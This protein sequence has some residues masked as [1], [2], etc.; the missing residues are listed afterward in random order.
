[1]PA[2]SV[3]G[4]R[5]GLKQEKPNPACGTKTANLWPSRAWLGILTNAR[6]R[7][8]MLIV[9]PTCRSQLRIGDD[10]LGR[11]IRCPSCKTVARIGASPTRRAGPEVE[12]DDDPPLA[13]EVPARESDEI[14]LEDEDDEDVPRRRRYKRKRGQSNLLIGAMVVG[15]ILLGLGVIGGVLWWLLGPETNSNLTPE[16]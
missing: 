13:M 2:L 3:T 4:N 9:C 1:M 16:N 10:M 7:T 15:A 11:E 12:S 14:E 5:G 6:L 8:S